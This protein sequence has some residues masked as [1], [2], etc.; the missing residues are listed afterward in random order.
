MTPIQTVIKDLSRFTSRA[1]FFLASSCSQIRGTRQ[2]VHVAARRV[3]VIPQNRA[4][5]AQPANAPGAAELRDLFA[6]S[7]DGQCGDAHDHWINANRGK[8]KRAPKL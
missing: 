6:V 5:Q 3:E 7:L 1:S 8:L 2:H 4:E